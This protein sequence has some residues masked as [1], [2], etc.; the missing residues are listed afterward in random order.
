[1]TN[2]NN[3]F[4]VIRDSREKPNFGWTYEEDSHCNGTIIQKVH[5]GDYTLEGLEDFFCIERKET[6]QEFARNCIQKE[7]WSKCME[8]MGECSHPYLIFEFGWK[9]IDNYP[10]SAKVPHYVRKKMMWKSGKP[11]IPIALIKSTIEIA[12][13]KYGIHVLACNDRFYAE[14]VAYRLMKKAYELRCRKL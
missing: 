2:I 10:R 3:K 8:R 13:E 4:T 7:R 9:D 12:R 5:A 11:K 1:V 6:I 14:R